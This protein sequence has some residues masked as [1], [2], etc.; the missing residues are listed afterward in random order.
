[1]STNELRTTGNARRLILQTP[2]GLKDGS[3]APST[4]MAIAATMKVLN[5]SLQ[6]EINAA[7][8]VI[9]AK[10]SGHDL[11]KLVDLGTMVLSG[12]QTVRALPSPPTQTV[13]GDTST[14]KD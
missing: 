1:M 4:G 10:Q 6:T 2:Q 8:L 9:Q 13:E 3:I 12:E 11:G 7:K 5:D 14:P